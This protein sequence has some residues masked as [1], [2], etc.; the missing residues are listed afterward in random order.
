MKRKVVFPIVLLVVALMTMS[1][2]AGNGIT[3]RLRPNKDKTYIITSKS[4]QTTTM[5][6]QSQ[7]IRNTVTMD[8]HQTFSATEVSSDHI[9][10]ETQVDAIKM[11]STTMGMTL[12]Y[13]S[14]NPQNTS[15]MMADQA[16]LFAKYIKKPANVT[17]DEQ[18]RLAVADDNNL[19]QLSNVIIA[20]PEEELSVG[21][22]WSYVN[23]RNINGVDVNI[24]M[25]YTVTSISK[26]SV[27]VSYT[28]SIDSKDVTGTY[29]GTASINLNTGIVMTN[30]LNSNISMNISEQGYD[31]QNTTI[32]T[33]TITVKEQ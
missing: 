26:K 10:F 15:P 13:D 11:T 24:N 31:M 23:A 17:Y 19:S 33:T 2:T 25:T 21:S 16:S 9:V 3:L 22:Q 20:L 30:S 32:G 12:T 18:G 4:T 8:G 7:T 29:D 5:K 1:F 27:E 28:G 6:I 14:D